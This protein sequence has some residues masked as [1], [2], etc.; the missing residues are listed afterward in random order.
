MT[1]TILSIFHVLLPWILAKSPLKEALLLF[2]FI[3]A[4]AEEQKRMVTCP[5]HTAGWWEPG[6]P[7][8]SFTCLT[9][10]QPKQARELPFPALQR[11]CFLTL[12]SSVAP[13]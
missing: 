3:D 9:T 7:P 5:N 4:K 1:G 12:K 11:I 10:L 13:R 6:Y 2:P 8:A